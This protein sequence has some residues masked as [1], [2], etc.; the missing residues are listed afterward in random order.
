MQNLYSLIR[1]G[2]LYRT[3]CFSKEGEFI[4]E[5][6]GRKWHRNGPLPW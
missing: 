5:P 6:T 2:Q 3:T 1:G 4:F